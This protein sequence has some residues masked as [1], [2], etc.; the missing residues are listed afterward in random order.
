VFLGRKTAIPRLLGTS[1]SV[2]DVFLFR[3]D[4]AHEALKKKHLYTLDTQTLTHPPLSTLLHNL[5]GLFSEK[6]VD[7][8]P[9]ATLLILPHPS[10]KKQIPGYEKIIDKLFALPGPLLLKLHPRDT[11]SAEC[12]R[13]QKDPKCQLLPL[14]IAMELLLFTISPRKVYSMR[15]SALLT[16]SWL[17]PHAAF[18]NIRTGTLYDTLFAKFGIENIAPEEIE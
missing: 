7:Y 6:D 17:M 8:P 15:S 3:P 14:E 2:K 4:L 5:A 9:D 16:L 13:C 11:Q 12:T 1:K 18:Y 10:V